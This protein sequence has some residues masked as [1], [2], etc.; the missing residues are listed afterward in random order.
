[1]IPVI[2]RMMNATNEIPPRQYSGYQYQIVFSSYF[3]AWLRGIWRWSVS[4]ALGVRSTRGV[5]GNWSR[6]QPTTVLFPS[7]RSELPAMLPLPTVD[8]P[9]GVRHAADEVAAFD[10]DR[11]DRERSVRGAMGVERPDV[12]RVVPRVHVL[13]EGHRLVLRAMAYAVDGVLSVLRVCR[14]GSDVPPVRRRVV[15]DVPSR[16]AAQVDA[17]V[18]RDDDPDAPR[19]PRVRIHLRGRVIV[20]EREPLRQAD[21]VRGREDGVVPLHADHENGEP[22]ARHVGVVLEETAPHARRAL[23]LLEVADLHGRA[24]LRVPPLRGRE[25]RV[26]DR[27]ANLAGALDRGRDE[28]PPR[29]GPEGGERAD[30][31]DG[32]P[33]LDPLPT[34]PAPVPLALFPAHR[35]PSAER[36]RWNNLGP[37]ELVNELVR[38]ELSAI[39]VRRDGRE[40]EDHAEEERHVRVRE[41]VGDAGG[42]L[43]REEDRERGE[44]ENTHDDAADREGGHRAPVRRVR[45]DDLRHGSPFRMWSRWSLNFGVE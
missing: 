35:S 18:E 38:H 41:A 33:E 43:E 39:N 24:D 16:I 25:F 14:R 12:R 42:H 34:G 32:H 13:D 21:V 1:M 6:I 28:L 29:D 2:V 15:D 45:P 22:R 30:C 27:L 37:S 10:L 31:P 20:E 5:G 7:C 26:E 17:P 4:I 36:P 11:D 40:D 8:V 19:L 44:P 9:G 3:S 23:P